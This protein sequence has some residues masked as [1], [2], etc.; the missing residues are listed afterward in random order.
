MSLPNTATTA[1]DSRA[2]SLEPRRD[3]RGQTTPPAIALRF[4]S[5]AGLI[6]LA[7]G[8]LNHVIEKM[9][10]SVIWY[11]AWHGVVPWGVVTVAIGFAVGRPARLAATAG[12][13][14]QIGLVLGYYWATF[15]DYGE[16]QWLGTAVYALVGLLMGPLYGTVG[17]LLTAPATRRHPIVVGPISAALLIDGFNQM[18]EAD[19]S[20]RHV[21]VIV[22]AGTPYLVLG[23]VVL[24]LMRSSWRDGVAAVGIS[25]AMTA[26]FLASLWV[27]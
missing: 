10:D 19:E 6:G 17:S 9:V 27:Y 14:T 24:C 21:S 22:A 2:R 8:V 25:A 4:L 5:A 15:V 1:D 26:V 11:Y 12:L 18:W 7:C 3:R 16:V 13:V 20:R 23:I